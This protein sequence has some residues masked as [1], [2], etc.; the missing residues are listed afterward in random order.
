MPPPLAIPGGYCNILSLEQSSAYY[1][2]VPYKRATTQ[3]LDGFDDQQLVLLWFARF[4]T[5]RNPYASMWYFNHS[6]HP[7]YYS[8]RAR[9]A[10]KI[11]YT[12]L[13]ERIK[14]M[15]EHHRATYD[16]CV[17]NIKSIVDAEAEAYRAK[18]DP[19]RQ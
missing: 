10:F 13:E 18:L 9:E 15:K 8:A 4:S 12:M 11:R 2:S 7:Q 19:T 6:F 17:Q 5:R 16:E 3:L 14:A 1:R